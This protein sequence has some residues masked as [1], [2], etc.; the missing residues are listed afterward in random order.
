MLS[1]CGNGP[2][3]LLLD[4]I[5]NL[6][7]TG[8]HRL[9]FRLEVVV[10]FVVLST[11]QASPLN[12]LLLRQSRQPL[13]RSCRSKEQRLLL[14]LL[15]LL[16]VTAGC[17]ERTTRCCG[18]GVAELHRPSE[19]T[20]QALASGGGRECHA[21]GDRSWNKSV[22]VGSCTEQCATAGWRM[23]LLD[24]RVHDYVPYIKKPFHNVNTWNQ[25]YDSNHR[26]ER[27]SRGRGT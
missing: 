1:S 6:V 21:Q 11:G 19:G 24:A 25:A 12:T 8:R 22:K 20:Q 9:P 3:H 13:R 16:A 7:S 5:S 18:G 2:T 10:G 15:L 23:A 4:E 17:S 26:Y 14:L 27:C